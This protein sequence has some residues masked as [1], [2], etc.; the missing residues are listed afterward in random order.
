[1]PR[2]RPIGAPA[3]RSRDIAAPAMI[4]RILDLH[5]GSTVLVAILAVAAI[6]AHAGAWYFISQHLGLSGTLASV[7]IAIAVLKHLGWLTRAYVLL[8]GRRAEVLLFRILLS[9]LQ[10][11]PPIASRVA[12]RRFF[13]PRRSRP[14]K[15]DA[16]R[17][18]DLALQGDRVKAYEGGKALRYW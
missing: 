15:L 13:R 10:F 14:R 4:R 8:Q 18:Y 17:T 5:V 6:A 11:F 2:P 3:L 1:M 16:L 7:L 12:Y 9:A